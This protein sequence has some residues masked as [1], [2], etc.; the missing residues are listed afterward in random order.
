[1]EITGDSTDLMRLSFNQFKKTV[2][3]HKNIITRTERALETALS[4]LT[5]LSSDQALE[6]EMSALTRL[7]TDVKEKK[8]HRGSKPKMIFRPKHRTEEPLFLATM[9]AEKVIQLAK[10]NV[11]P[12]RR[13]NKLIAAGAQTRLKQIVD[14]NTEAE[15]TLSREKKVLAKAQRSEKKIKQ[16]TMQHKL[17]KSTPP[18]VDPKTFLTSQLFEMLNEEEEETADKK[19]ADATFDLQT[20]SKALSTIVST[21]GDLEH[22]IQATTSEISTASDQTKISQRSVK[23]ANQNSI[24]LKKKLN[25][26]NLNEDY[27]RETVEWCHSEGPKRLDSIER[28]ISK[29]QTSITS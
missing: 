22:A 10:E 3:A 9:S 4:A 28:L 14:R 8:N 11:S 25:R 6:T 21:N 18:L 5:S 16:A 26:T 1:M 20:V 19:K 7:S 2:S 27:F 17:L 23:K 15:V 24:R 12:L 29:L 13:G